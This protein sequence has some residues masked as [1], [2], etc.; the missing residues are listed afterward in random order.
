[1]NIRCKQIW[2]EIKTIERSVGVGEIFGQTE[3]NMGN[4]CKNKNHS[5]LK[6]NK[7]QH[8][9]TIAFLGGNFFLKNSKAMDNTNTTKSSAVLLLYLK[10]QLAN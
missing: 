9:L 4:G 10:G 1:M 6:C 5:V 3:R 2:S 8:S 7:K